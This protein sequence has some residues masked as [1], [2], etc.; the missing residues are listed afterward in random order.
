MLY[1]ENCKDQ[2]D[3]KEHMQFIRFG[4]Y[5]ILLTPLLVSTRFTLP[6]LTP[7]VLAFQIL[8]D[9]VMAAAC[10]ME[11]RQISRGR[12]SPSLPSLLPSSALSVALAIFLGYSVITAAFG[13]DLQRSL[14]GLEDRQDGL[15][16][17]FHLYGWFL[18]LVWLARHQDV[19]ERYLN[20]SFWVSSI[21]ALSALFQWAETRYQLFG[22]LSPSLIG[23]IHNQIGDKAGG[24]LGNPEFLGAYLL[25]HAFYGLYF[26]RSQF[27]SVP[28][29]DSA[30]K[31]EHRNKQK[32]G[33]VRF[34]FF[35]AAQIV[36]L[37]AISVGET[38]GI[39]L[40]L[41]FGLLVLSAGYALRDSSRRI[42]TAAL[43]LCL[44]LVVGGMTVWHFRNSA[45]VRKV[46]VLS[47]LSEGLSLENES[48]WV[49]LR[50]WK[51]SLNGFR[52]HPA[53]GWGHDNAFYA[54][55]KYYNP[56]LV[57]YRLGMFI[58][59]WS[60]KS[61]NAYLDLLVE[62]GIAGA[63]L[64]LMVVAAVLRA[65]WKM[66]SRE[67]AFHLA[68]GFTAY[69]TSRFVAFDTFGSYFGLFLFLS[70]CDVE[71][72]G[73]QGSARAKQQPAV[74]SSK[75]ERGFR[76]KGAI[77]ASLMLAV[78]CAA[79]LYLNVEMGM[80]SVACAEAQNVFPTYPEAGLTLYKAA[81]QRFFPYND[82]EKLQCAAL[83]IKM[84]VEGQKNPAVYAKIDQ[85]LQLGEE[86]VNAH[87]RDAYLCLWLSQLYTN[88]G[89]NIDKKY[90]DGGGIF[91][92]RAWELSPMR[93]EVI[94]HLARTYSLAGEPYRAVALNR[95]MVEAYPGYG[96]G[97]FYYGL[98][99]IEVNR[100]EDAKK[101]IRKALETGFQPQE[102]DESQIVRQ[103]LAP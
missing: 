5:G 91:G 48:V 30:K 84:V 12:S 85:A 97:H 71:G 95:R 44:V 8:V 2:A 16:F 80:A 78:A 20:F 11:L 21:A 75:S 7:K 4:L 39:V 47:R 32:R 64:F 101:E 87:P 27:R 34:A 23:S 88:L 51:S 70:W 45:I 103:L 3:R 24:V 59:T 76:I 40:G 37:V 83:I 58:G 41:G 66:P 96:L 15:V 46:P 38:R 1:N 61:H 26:I 31:R 86:A 17:W 102:G 82:K 60:D 93:Q 81:F 92:G 65:L 25:F 22:F 68:G 33:R 14:W 36:L 56:E 19:L 79:F 42:R 29:S 94:L 43:G 57:R 49:R 28:R 54:L 18:V 89:I 77:A 63:I 100:R 62:K 74:R 10:L 53:T 98:S 55:N 90:L 69:V 72:H 99:L 73:K 9:L 6:F 35:I 67:A 50:L 52:D 13:T